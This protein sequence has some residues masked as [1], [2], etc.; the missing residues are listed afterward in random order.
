MLNTGQSIT[1]AAMA[2][3]QLIGGVTIDLSGTATAAIIVFACADLCA[4]GLL[5]AASRARSGIAQAPAH[6]P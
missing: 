1:T 2:I 5:A 6:G 4:A 3:G